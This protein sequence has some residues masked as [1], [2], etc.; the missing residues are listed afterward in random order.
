MMRKTTTA[1]FLA[2]LAA[3]L[4][5]VSPAQAVLP[6]ESPAAVQDSASFTACDATGH[7][8]HQDVSW[9]ER[10]ITVNGHLQPQIQGNGTAYCRN[11]VTS[12]ACVSISGYFRFVTGAGNVDIPIQCGASIGHSACTE[13]IHGDTGWV[14]I[15]CHF[16]ATRYFGGDLTANTGSGTAHVKGRTADDLGTYLCETE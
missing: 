11:K 7:C 3:L 4:L 16:V 10:T 14:T 8:I 12:Y 9:Q 15:P 5:P 13:F 6:G 1:L 2:I